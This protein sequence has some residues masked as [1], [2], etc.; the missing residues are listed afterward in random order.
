[1]PS[2]AS[3]TAAASTRF[4]RCPAIAC[5]PFSWSRAGRGGGPARP[6]VTA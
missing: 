3:S 5:G 6:G 1:M 4:H 2:G